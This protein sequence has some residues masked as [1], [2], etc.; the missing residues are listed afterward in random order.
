MVSIITAVFKAT[1][2]LLVNKGRDHA[3][4]KLKEGDVTEQKFRV[5]IVR[6]L[7]DIKSKLDGLARKDLLAS[8]SFFKEGIFLLYDVFEKTNFDE[9]CKA[10]AQTTAVATEEEAM[11]VS[12]Q[13]PSAGTKTVSLAKELSSLRLSNSDDS[14]RELLSDAKRRFKEARRKATEAFGNEALNTS[15]RI[16]AMMVRVMGTILEKVDNPANALAACRVSLEELHA[17]PAV[18]KSFNVELTRGFK[19]RFNKDEH[20]EII[21]AVCRMNHVIYDVTQ[22]VGSENKVLFI[23]PWIDV[24]AEK[25]DPFRDARVTTI[26]GVQHTDCNFC[27]WSF[28]REG[29]DEEHK[30]KTVSGISA[31]SKEQFIVGDNEDCT[32][33]VFDHE[34]KFLHSLFRPGRD[35]NSKVYGICDVATDKNDNVY[36]LATLQK[37][38]TELVRGVC[39]FDEDNNFHHSFALRAGFRGYAL[40]FEESSK[41]V[42][43]LGAYWTPNWENDSFDCNHRCAVE[44]YEINGDILTSFVIQGTIFSVLDITARNDGHVLVLKTDSVQVFSV[45][46]DLQSKWLKVA[47]EVNLSHTLYCQKFHFANEHV[48]IVTN[49]LEC[50]HPELKRLCFVS[51]YTK[52]GEFVYSIHLNSPQTKVTTIEM[53]VTVNGRIAIAYN[54]YYQGRQGEIQVL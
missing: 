6:E 15:D 43:V 46:G 14:T 51:M 28:G 7:D 54:H 23:W 25:V 48:F 8:I 29:Y 27:A 45:Y 41:R 11:D 10:A 26:L 52:D 31:N 2:G 37:E 50:I 22:M 38:A 24:G 3:A 34:G 21:T 49:I 53:T 18:Q 30:L 19:S 32:V 35:G 44:V 5:L 12:L 9:N 33:K 20:T 17:M 1:I 39:V 13:S 42:V 40:T 16:L 36:V 47:E 4:A